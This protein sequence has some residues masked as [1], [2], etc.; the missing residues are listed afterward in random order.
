M[1]AFERRQGELFVEDVPVSEIAR[2]I[3]TPL[4]IYS[5]SAFASAYDALDRAFAQIPHLICYSLKSNMNLAVIRLLTRRGAGVDVTS[6]GELFRALR[7][8]A[9]AGKIVYSGV[10]KRDDEIDAALTEGLTGSS[11]PS[12]PTP[13]GERSAAPSGKS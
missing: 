6:R 2:D 10:G 4:Y 13:A 3:G 7:A 9:N 8:G 11:T 12:P 5:A 1:T